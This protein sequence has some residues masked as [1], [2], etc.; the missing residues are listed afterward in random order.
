MPEILDIDSFLN[1]AQQALVVDVRSPGEFAQG[2]IP[3]AV[4]AP[5]FLDA[6]RAE[7]GTLYKKKGREAAMLLGLRHAGA[8]LDELGAHLAALPG[9]EVLLHCWRGGMRSASMAW[10]AEMM[11][12][13]VATL[14]GGYK[15]FRRWAIESTGHGEALIHVVAGPTGSGKTQVLHA[16]EALGE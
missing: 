14:G 10:L 1:R 15:T 11:G 13:R 6:E 16:L 8:R 7:V 4:N 5:L 3:G 9:R 2:H 12:R